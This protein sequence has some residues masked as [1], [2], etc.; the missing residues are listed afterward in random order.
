[1]KLFLSTFL[2]AA[3]LVSTGFTDAAFADSWEKRKELAKRYTREQ[4]AKKRLKLADQLC[5]L[6]EAKFCL[7]AVTDEPSPEKKEKR[8]RAVCDARALDCVEAA[9]RYAPTLA[10]R[11]ELLQTGCTR[12]ASEACEILFYDL[13]TRSADGSDIPKAQNLVAPT[14]RRSSSNLSDTWTKICAAAKDLSEPT[15]LAYRIAAKTAEVRSSRESLVNAGIARTGKVE[16]NGANADTLLL[17]CEAGN[18]AACDQYVHNA[19]YT[20][21]KNRNFYL[22]MCSLGSA[23]A[24]GSAD[25]DGALE[26]GCF[27]LGWDHLCE[28]YSAR[29]SSS[30]PEKAKLAADAQMVACGLKNDFECASYTTVA[31]RLGIEPTPDGGNLPTMAILSHEEAARFARWRDRR[32][33]E[34]AHEVCLVQEADRLAAAVTQNPAASRQALDNFLRK[35]SGIYDARA[36]AKICP[37][38]EEQ[39]DA[40]RLV[41]ALPQLGLDTL[42]VG[43]QT[44]DARFASLHFQFSYPRIPG[45]SITPDTVF[46]SAVST[47]SG[48]QPRLFPW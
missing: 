30:N 14:C 43:D 6:G 16:I 24:C 18:I 2:V 9:E 31:A 38:R 12:G 17:W 13:A 47:A 36:M 15:S 21:E 8:L 4:D 1:M 7:Y 33:P 23:A 34:G 42:K 3:L 5:K 29:W 27:K 22:R 10:L 35:C 37:A 20:V 39:P 40:G 25:S 28:N 32:L 26:R 44:L 45:S 19:P 11:D 46:G 48:M 41:C